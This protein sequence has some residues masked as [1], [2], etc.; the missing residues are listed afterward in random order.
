VPSGLTDYY[1]Y[2]RDTKE[3]IRI[4]VELELTRDEFEK[5]FQPLPKIVRDTI[6]DQLGEKGFLLFISRQIV[7]PQIG[8]RTE[9]LNWVT[10][11]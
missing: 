9:Y 10:F 3:P 8:W 6:K 1:W 7:S 4:S 5:S 2:N 11:N